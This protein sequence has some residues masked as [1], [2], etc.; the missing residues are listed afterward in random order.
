MILDYHTFNNGLKLPICPEPRTVVNTE[1]DYQ[2][3]AF[4]DDKI[5]ELEIF[6]LNRKL[7]EPF[8][9]WDKKKVLIFTGLFFNSPDFFTVEYRVY[10]LVDQAQKLREKLDS[11]AALIASANILH[12]VNQCSEERVK[13]RRNSGFTLPNYPND[14]VF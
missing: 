5:G 2:L 3:G 13:M 14:D 4:C 11:I 9:S 1:M 8:V 10:G 7:C 12:Q 6:F